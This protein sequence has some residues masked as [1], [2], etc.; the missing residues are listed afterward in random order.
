MIP[1]DQIEKLQNSVDIVDIIGERIDLKRSGS[2]YKA[3]CP[4]H[5]E[6]TPSFMVSQAKQIYKCFGCGAS[7]DS[8]KF[9]MSYDNLSY[10]DAI[11]HLASRYGIEIVEEHSDRAYEKSD[12]GKKE[13]LRILNKYA[14]DLFHENLIKEIN[15]NTS[16][17]AEYLKMRKLGRDLVEKFKI[18]FAPDQW[19]T[20]KEDKRFSGQSEEILVEAGLRKK[21]EKGKIYDQFRNRLMFPIFDA[22]GNVAAFSGRSLSDE[23]QPKYLNS[24][25][26]LVY[27]KNEVLYGLFQAMDTVRK[28]K[29]IILVEGNI[30]IITMHKF[31][32]TNTVAICGTSFTENHARLIKRNADKITILLDGDEAGKKSA[33]KTAE[34]LAE[35]GMVPGIVLLPGESDPDSFIYS[36]G[37][38]ELDKL[39]SSPLNLVDLVI[40]LGGGA[41]TDANEKAHL[42]KNL[43]GSLKH[44]KDPVL[45][46]LYTKE[47]SRKSGVDINVIKRE[48]VNK[49]ERSAKK[50]RQ[51]EK[52]HE[53]YY[54]DNDDQ[55]EFG[56]IYLMLTD[57]TAR[58]RFLAEITEN[59]LKNTEA[60]KM[61]LKIY[62]LYEDGETVKLNNILIDFSE[63]FKD[64]MI[65]FVIE[66]DQAFLGGK[67]TTNESEFAE[68]IEKAYRDNIKKIKMRRIAQK[69]EDLRSELKYTEDPADQNEI[70]KKLSLIKA[71]Q[72]EL[73]N[74][75]E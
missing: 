41:K 56:I 30:D 10:P 13:L 38:D 26:T 22:M 17:V 63:K 47:A 35:A 72:G 46:D 33:L 75:Q 60:S 18:G 70:L 1:K 45:F 68:K 43:I 34:I 21:S 25:E 57:E 50:V 9:V 40:Q 74:G 15:A 12:D 23:V 11:R 8:I 44:I 53:R 19:N 54:P 71:E 52:K 28:T 14:C 4:F 27:K 7:G 42:A 6:K 48:I 37:K 55:M 49:A 73:V 67:N 62:E 58:S 32:Y 31:G 66:Q 51:E 65:G 29:E 59:D 69:M 61:F 2:N 16:D 3:R 36:Q 24:P 39:L 20:L 64:F 5:D